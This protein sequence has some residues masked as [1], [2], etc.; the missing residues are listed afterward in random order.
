MQRAFIGMITRWSAAAVY[1][2]IRIFDGGRVTPRSP[3]AWTLVPVVIALLVTVA[4]QASGQ[5]ATD[6]TQVPPQQVAAKKWSFSASAYGYLVPDDQD[7]VQPTF[8]ADRGPLHLEARY[9]YEA[10]KTGSVWAGYNFSL[11]QKL[12]FDFTPM[13]GGI[14]GDTSGIAPGLKMTVSWWKLEL[15]SESEYVF[16]AEDNS[17]NFAYTWSQVTLS[18]MDWFRFGFVAQRTRAYQS[19]LDIQ[20]GLL[21]GFSYKFADFGAYLFNPDQD[22]PTIVFSVAVNF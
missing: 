4:G 9:N 12:T 20:R 10:L 18:P 14:F 13:L 5:E 2:S 16:D 21:A 1:S 11:G 3:A 19:D 6:K 8:T 22:K 15:Y 7:F 17:A